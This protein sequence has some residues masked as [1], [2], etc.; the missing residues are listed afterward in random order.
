[1]FIS[2]EIKIYI[3][4]AVCLNFSKSFDTVNHNILMSMLLHNGIGGGMQS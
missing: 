3:T 4:I 2:R 1:M